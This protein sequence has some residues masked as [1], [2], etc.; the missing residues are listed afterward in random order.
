MSKRDFRLQA[1]QGRGHLFVLCLYEKVVEGEE[2]LLLGCLFVRKWY[3]SLLLW[4]F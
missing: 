1:S 2:F 3:F 4:G